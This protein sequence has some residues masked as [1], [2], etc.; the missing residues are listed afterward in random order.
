MMADRV[1]SG[2]DVNKPT[3]YVEVVTLHI[4]LCILLVWC[5]VVGNAWGMVDG[6]G[7][8]G[9]RDLVGTWKLKW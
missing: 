8:M 4:A 3:Q 1:V 5:F 7:R 9:L 2:N 6:A